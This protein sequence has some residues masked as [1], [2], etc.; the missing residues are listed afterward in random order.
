MSYYSLTTYAIYVCMALAIACS[1]IANAKLL[2]DQKTTFRVFLW[3]ARPE[4][5]AL[6]WKFR[7]ASVWLAA[8]AFA[9]VPLAGMVQF[10][11]SH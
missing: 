1:V 4:F 11:E 2:P 8:A 9:L 6:G 5:S 10:L 7:Q 3:R